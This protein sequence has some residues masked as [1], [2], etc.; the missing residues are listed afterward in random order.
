[1]LVELDIQNF[2]IIKNLKIKFKKNMTV[3]IGETGAGKSILIDALSLLLGH[4]AQSEMIRSGE[5]KAVVTGLFTLEES[6]KQIVENLCSE[7]GLPLDGDDLIISR[8]LSNKGRNVIRINGQLTTI[9]VLAQIGQYLVDIHGQSD[10]QI[11]MN[12]ERQIDLVDEYAGAI[13]KVE[14]E[15][16]QSLFKKWVELTNKLKH[17]QKGAQELAQRHDILQFQKDELDSADLTDIDEDEK[18]EQEYSKLNNYQKIAETANY[19]MQVFDDD[20]HGLTTLLGNAQNAADE[21]AEYGSDFK[22]MAQSLSDGVYSL[23]DSRSE[24]GNIMDNLDFDEERFQY[25]T[26]RLD[27]LNNLKKKYGPD[28]SDVFNFYQK[29]S[30]ELSQFEMGGLDEDK[31]QKEISQLEDNMAASAQ[32]LHQMREKTSSQLEKEIR[33]ELADLFMEKARFSIRFV[34]SKTFNELGT[35]EVAFYIA[36]NPGEEL[37]PLVKIVSGGE[38]SRLILALKTIFSK[39]EPVGT[40][41]FDEIDTGVSGRVSAA[42][43]KKMHS[44]GQQKQVIAI[45]HSVQVAASSDWRYKIEKHVEDGNTFTQVRI[46]DDQESVKAIAQMMAGINITAAAEQNAADLIKRSHEK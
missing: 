26:N 23:S 11:L 5:K 39:V 2:A 28:L 6:Q 36:P 25:V 30:K 16:Y 12:Q 38:Q 41:V 29:I 17:L 1:M 24:L 18:L 33:S 14:L 4:R 10:Q 37:M 45:T 31:L 35:D 9:T 27:T 40:M 42:I 8:E 20:E 44:I 46:L 13:F 22:N 15:K 7:Y 43:G 34:Q 21:L 3:L 32:K 19:L